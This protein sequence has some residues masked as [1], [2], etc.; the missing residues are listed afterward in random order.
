LNTGQFSTQVFTC[1]CKISNGPGNRAPKP[2]RLRPTPY[3]ELIVV[4]SQKTNC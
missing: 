4:A 2:K 3:A 1:I